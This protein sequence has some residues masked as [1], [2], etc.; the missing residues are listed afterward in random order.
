MLSQMGNWFYAHLS[1]VGV[2]LLALN[3]IFQKLPL[4]Q[5]HDLIS[6]AGKGLKWIWG[7]IASRLTPAQQAG[8]SEDLKAFVAAV[9]REEIAKGVGK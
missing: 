7:R 9:V 1:Q 6:L 4:A 5:Q 8:M 3:T 2:G